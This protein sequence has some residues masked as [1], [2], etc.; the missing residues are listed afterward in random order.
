MLLQLAGRMFLSTCRPNLTLATFFNFFITLLTPDNDQLSTGFF[1]PCPPHPTVN[2][3]Q[4]L[5]WH[6]DTFLRWKSGFA[7]NLPMWGSVYRGGSLV[8]RQWQCLWFNNN[9]YHL[10][11]KRPSIGLWV[12]WIERRR[13]CLAAI[14]EPHADTFTYSGGGDVCVWWKEVLLLLL[15]FNVILVVYLAHFAECIAFKERGMGRKERV[16]ERQR[17]NG[18]VAKPKENSMHCPGDV[19]GSGW[20]K[21]LMTERERE[22]HLCYDI[23]V[24][25]WKK[26]GFGPDGGIQNETL[27]EVQRSEFLRTS[28][29]FQ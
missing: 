18:K 17:E 29:S 19:R 12:A 16:R 21:R 24:Y 27:G 2:T 23:L 26:R 10:R 6:F 15:Y 28:L 14:S 4:S 13:V 1:I 8:W 22:S 7:D 25:K 5:S 11:E 3:Q 9:N 20:R